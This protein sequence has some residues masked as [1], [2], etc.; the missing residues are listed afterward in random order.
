MSTYNTFKTQIGEEKYLSCIANAKHRV[1]LTKLRISAHRLGIE[2]G[3]Y[4][5]IERNERLCIYCN[6]RAVEDEYHFLLIC[7]YYYEIR[8]SC[9]P[10]YFRTWP[11]INKFKL[12]LSSQQTGVLNKLGKF[13]FLANQKRENTIN[14]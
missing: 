5:N 1:A 9:L 4:R 6:M 12:L 10:K 2:E 11:T 8:T 14:L 13:I 7:P 3:R